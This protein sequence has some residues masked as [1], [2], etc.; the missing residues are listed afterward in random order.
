MATK[1]SGIEAIRDQLLPAMEALVEL[2]RS[3]DK[4]EQLVFFERITRGVAAARE[5]DDLAGPFM[6]LSTSA[7]LGFHFSPV[8]QFTLDGILADA[9][10]I[11][12]T[13]SAPGDDPH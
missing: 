4:P 3:E 7:F 13:L 6:E 9:Q 12:H 11:S 1:T 5:P 10:Q 2:V 8:V